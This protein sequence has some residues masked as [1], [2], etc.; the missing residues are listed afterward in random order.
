MEG[1][2]D[3]QAYMRQIG[4]T[5]NIQQA[6]GSLMSARTNTMP[7]WITGDVG[8]TQ[9]KDLT[10]GDVRLSRLNT[11]ED[12]FNLLNNCLDPNG[13]VRTQYLQKTIESSSP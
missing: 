9:V 12:V 3:Y 6:W 8:L 4:T 7:W 10:G 2:T 11:I 5:M 1:F 13:K